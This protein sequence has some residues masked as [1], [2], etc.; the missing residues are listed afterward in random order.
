VSIDLARFGLAVGHATDAVGATGCTV[1][2]GID[3][4][5][6]GAV[7]VL[8]RATGSRELA[9]LEPG[10]LV[11][12]V[13]GIF[14]TGGSA[15]GLDATAGVMRWMEARGR[16][17]PVGGGV[18]P[19]VPGAVI[20]DLRPLGRFDARPTPEMAYAAC[21]AAQSR[22]IAEG[23]VGAGT[24]ATVGKL[25]GSGGSMKGGVGIAMA[26]GEG[27][28]AVAIAVVNAYGDVRD[29][30]GAI[31]AG[32]RDAE[33]RFIDSAAAIAKGAPSGGFRA[34]SAGTNTTLV[35]VALDAAYTRLELQ[36]IAKS[37][38]AAMHRH[39]TPAGTSSDGDIVFALA[40]MDGR[41]APLA[42]GEQLAAQ[43]LGAAI[44]RAVRLATPLA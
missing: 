6:R 28:A 17:F 20:F 1:V 43:A 36:S 31:I 15:Y 5:H 27:C 32:A 11:E 3:G 4:P 39:I 35:V 21:D 37:A 13:D 7:A 12:R 26:E 44:E 23:S 14:L 19:I 9:L 30:S 33:G 10:H 16:G 25:K 41:R 42:Q 34:E 40:P 24:G 22:D 8:G 38:T 29:S 18:V 2:R